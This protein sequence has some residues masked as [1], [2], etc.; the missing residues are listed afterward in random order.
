MFFR[1]NTIISRLLLAGFAAGTL[2]AMSPAKPGV[3]P[4]AKVL[5]F[6][7]RAAQTYHMGGLAAA[8]QRVKASQFNINRDMASDTL[9]MSFPVI[10]GNYADAGDPAYPIQN[11][12]QELF[13][14]PW[15][16]ITMR[17]HYLEMS[18]NQFHLSGDVYGWYPVSQGHAY[19]EG[20]QTEPFDNGFTGPP[21]GVG[22]FLQETLIQADTTVD[23]S[24]YDND[25]PDGIA[26]SGDDDGFVDA[27]FFVHSGR[28]GEGGGPYIWSHRYRYSAWWGSAFTTN[29]SSANGGM[30]RVN[31]YIMQPALSTSGGMIE[32][33]VFSHEF[34]HAIGLPDLY[35]TDYSSDGIGRWGLMG[36]GSWNTP[37]EPAHL[38]AWSKEV[39][40][41][42]TPVLIEENI[43]YME[44]PNVV[45]NP[46]VLKLWRFGQ[47]DPWTSWWG[48]G[49]DV[50][51][52][53][54]LV[55]NRQRIGSDV[56]LVGTGLLI[57]HVDNTQSTNSNDS[58]RM[59]DMAAADGTFGNGTSSGD[60]WPGSTN[61]RNFDFETIP[62][63]IGWD[64]TNTQ[65][66]VLNISDSD[67]TMYADVEVYESTP[68]L[69][70][71]DFEIYD[72]DGDEVLVPGE[73]FEVWAEVTNSGGAATGISG[74]IFSESP[75]VEV[76]SGTAEFEN[77]DFME[78]AMGNLPFELLV[79][80]SAQ[81]GVIDL[82]IQFTAT[83]TEDTSSY[84][85]SVGIGTPEVG[86]V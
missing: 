54:Y 72:A 21:G 49:L 57:W 64:G 67:S 39:L 65:V 28:G 1:F 22:A 62:A 82:T 36:G 74:S 33:G 56:H 32:I 23:F 68:H 2:V 80:D 25:G 19:Y 20:S 10:V 66:A 61:N 29:D 15:P 75:Y 44:I 50:G 69:S 9:Y 53:Y 86:L 6:H 85:I 40:G 11:L 14:G 83:E 45:E 24:Q 41:W 7:Q 81:T 30:I 3:T 35:D 31:D 46:Y 4:S 84:V 76:I 43:N 55:E 38:S 42:V 51:R 63:A 47:P 52:E 60:P 58:H 13:D 34:G 8:L 17:E 5:E 70:L 26:N 79:A 78:S 27:C 48:P 12:Q 18:Y 37:T 77:L 59:V 16:T 73:L 71:A